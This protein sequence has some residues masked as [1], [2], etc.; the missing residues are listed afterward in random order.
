MLI[1]REVHRAGVSQHR[2]RLGKQVVEH[3]RPSAFPLLHVHL[4]GF[5]EEAAVGATRRVAE[6]RLLQERAAAVLGQLEMR[7][8]G[9][10]AVRHRSG[11]K[12]RDLIEVE[13]GRGGGIHAVAPGL[14]R[15]KAGLADQRQRVG[16]AELDVLV[17][18][19]DFGR[20]FAAIHLVGR[21]PVTQ[22]LEGVAGLVECGRNGV[23]GVALHSE[24][25]G[26]RG[27]RPCRLWGQDSATQGRQ[28]R[29]ESREPRLTS[30]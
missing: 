3:G 24:F 11:R 16:D 10:A 2:S 15:N 9:E 20:R 13:A 19:G 21:H 26:E 12:Q 5:D 23:A 29:H 17:Q 8:V 27:N 25:P 22:T 30:W 14:F 1:Q 4:A 6:H 28:N 7:E 18:F